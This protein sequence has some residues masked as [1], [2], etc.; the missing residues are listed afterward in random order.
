MTAMKTSTTWRLAIFALALTGA[1]GCQCDL[2]RDASTRHRKSDD[3]RSSKKN[4][5]TPDVVR[6]VEPNDR[7]KNASLYEERTVAPGSPIL[8][9]FEGDEGALGTDDLLANPNCSLSD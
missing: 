1:A 5:K 4:A 3:H 2:P 6:E 9:A 7:P 8:V